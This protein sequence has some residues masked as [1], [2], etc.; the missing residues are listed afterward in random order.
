MN[1]WVMNTNI[2]PT[3][4]LGYK[5]AHGVFMGEETMPWIV[6]DMMDGIAFL[7]WSSSI[8]AFWQEA[9]AFWGNQ[10]PHT[11]HPG[12]SRYIVI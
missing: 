7:A 8:V 3:G 2:A 4:V 12:A 11:S 10:P 5:V 6:S 1:I 9:R